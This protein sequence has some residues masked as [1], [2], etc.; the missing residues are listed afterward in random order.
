MKKGEKPDMSNGSDFSS[1]NDPL[2]KRARTIRIIKTVVVIAALVTFFVIGLITAISQGK[3]SGPK[4]KEEIE[5]D[6]RTATLL[7]EMQPL[8]ATFAVEPLRADGSI[9]YDATI[10]NPLVDDTPTVVLADEPKKEDE[11]DASDCSTGAGSLGWL[12]CPIIDISTTFI[13][14]R[15]LDW[16]EPALQINMHL[17]G[18]QDTNAPTYTA[19]GVFRDIA[20]IAFVIIFLIVIFSQ[21]LGVGVDNYGIKKIL[22]KLIVGALLINMS[23]IICQLAIDVANIV[24][25]GIGGIFKWITENRITMPEKLKVE[26]VELTT[27]DMGLLDDGFVYAGG[28]LTLVLGA[29]SVASVISQGA[30]IIVPVL[31]L[32]VSALISVFT[33]IAIL[34][35][36]QAAAVLLVVVS[37]LAF[38]CYMLPNTKK[39]FDKWLKAFEG[40]LIAFPACA[41]LIYGGDMVGHILLSTSNGST[42]IMISAAAI[43]MA[44]VFFIPK[45]IRSSMGAIATTMS[46]L[47]R[48]FTRNMRRVGNESRLAKEIRGNHDWRQQRA[49]NRRRAGIDKNGNET[50]RGARMRMRAKSGSYRALQLSRSR[51]AVLSDYNDDAQSE[52]MIGEGGMDYFNTMKASTDHKINQQAIAG[53]EQQI[54]LTGSSIID[55]TT[56]QEIRIDP[57]NFDSLARALTAAMLAGNE[58]MQAA[59]INT[60]SKRGDKGRE[61]V[62]E[63]IVKAEEVVSAPGYGGDVDDFRKSQKFAAA[64][65]LDN[66]SDAYENNSKSTYDWADRQLGG[67]ADVTESD[68]TVRQ[69]YSNADDKQQWVASNSMKNFTIQVGDVKQSTLLTMDDG[70]MTRLDKSVDS[71]GDGDEDKRKRAQL[72]EAIDGALKSEAATN[73]KIE[74]KTALIALRNKLG[75]APGAPTPPPA[76]T[77]PSP[78]E[79]DTSTWD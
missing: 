40:L 34:G 12:I 2:E 11:K 72:I 62:R 78:P 27:G 33:L 51:A 28:V 19:W 17:F 44:P 70:E 73:A 76:P 20:N 1:R 18:A 31:L 43:S 53:L 25:Y 69:G 38:V 58:N 66:F 15:Y 50:R 67:D 8:S 6:N 26:G 64:H 16:I 23:Y 35:M 13:K 54:K 24:G 10:E 56:G 52:R 79:D 37:P 3:F 21:L 49:L 9:V 39:I 68:G 55:P 30:T 77:P 7:N 74:R 59:L 75:S 71:L 32:A 63:A 22:P 45:L 41:A 60:L 42:W 29:L 65:I 57:S 36:R 47:S 5:G 4:R 61:K 48:N 14:D 46:G